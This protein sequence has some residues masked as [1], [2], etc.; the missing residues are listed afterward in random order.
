MSRNIKLRTKCKIVITPSTPFNFAGTFWKP[1][2]YQSKLVLYNAGFVYHGI[3]IGREVYGLKISDGSSQNES[4]VVFEIWSKEKLSDREKKDISAELVWRYD[5]NADIKG[6][7]LIA[8]KDE[9]LT[10]AYKRWAGM[11]PSIAYS[12][13]EFL[14]VTITLQNTTVRRSVQMM[15]SLLQ[16][17]GTCIEYDNVKV[18]LIWQPTRLNR[19]TEEDIRLLKVGYRARMIKRI[20]DSFSNKEIDENDL[21]EKSICDVRNEV[22]ALYGVGPQSINYILFEVFKCY[23]CVNHFSPWEAKIISMLLFGNKDTSAEIILETIERRWGVWKM[24]AV[25]YLFED[26]FWR[27]SN[28]PIPWLDDEIRD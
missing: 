16:N 1:S 4:K 27:R 21:R 22:L 10:D 2:H 9:I 25:H 5:L 3:R 26:I 18:Y 12:L 8:S 20:S 24:L 17:Y 28:D 13:Y 6:F 19:V 23:G 14:M 7:A 11:R 15:D